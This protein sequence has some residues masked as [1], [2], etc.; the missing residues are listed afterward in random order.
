L[1]QKYSGPPSE[2]TRSP[3]GPSRPAGFEKNRSRHGGPIR[4]F[5]V[6]ARACEPVPCKHGRE[7]ATFLVETS[8]SPESSKTFLC[9]GHP[10][11]A[12]LSALAAFLA[13]GVRPRTPLAKAIV[14][15]L[16]IK[17]FAIAGFGVFM[18]PGSGPPVVDPSA[19]SRLIGPSMSS[20][21]EGG[22]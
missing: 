14:L 18:L 21:N 11:N 10:L 16:V 4:R 22:R 3:S 12:I 15:V 9:E 5:L 1:S 8:R 6:A 2:N 17:L 13:A 20:P 19:V 7:S